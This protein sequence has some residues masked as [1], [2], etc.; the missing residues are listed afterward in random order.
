MELNVLDAYG[1]KKNVKLDLS[2]IFQLWLS[3]SFMGKNFTS[4]VVYTLIL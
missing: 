3:L 1:D 4:S 2:Q